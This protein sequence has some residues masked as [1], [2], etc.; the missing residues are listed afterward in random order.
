VIDA[1]PPCWPP[2]A[3]P[4]ITI[5]SSAAVTGEETLRT[6]V[7]SGSG[8]S[9]QSPEEQ[10]LNVLENL[11]AD[12]D[13]RGSAPPSQEAVSA[14]R[15]WLPP[16]IEAAT[17]SGFPWRAPHMSVSEGGEVT[18]EWW[19]GDRKVTLY[20]SEGAPEFVKVW[21]PHIFDQMES[22]DILSSDSFLAIW[23]WLN[24]A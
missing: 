17:L 2:Q 15:E 20:F 13:L 6:Y 4:Y 23:H 18:F 12:W 10:R 8:S 16:L 11:K 24:A 5:V 22:G 9:L 7:R 1:Y 19:S 14:A 3:S 21:G